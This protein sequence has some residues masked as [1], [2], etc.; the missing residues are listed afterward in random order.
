MTIIFM[1]KAPV[2]I[3]RMSEESLD[4]FGEVF[5]DGNKEWRP[6]VHPRSVNLQDCPTYYSQ[7][8][9]TSQEG[10]KA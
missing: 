2:D 10:Q 7:L 3:W 9:P 1:K 5:D 4:N 6:R 8:H